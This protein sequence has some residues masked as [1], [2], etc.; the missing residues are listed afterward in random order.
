MDGPTHFSC[1][2]VAGRWHVLGATRARQVLLSRLGYVPVQLAH[3]DWDGLDG[4]QQQERLLR[5]LLAAAVQA[6]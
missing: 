2:K 4:Q 1:N 6:V 3:H 5:E